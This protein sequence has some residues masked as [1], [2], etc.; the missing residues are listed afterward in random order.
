MQKG[1]LAHEKIDKDVL[2]RFS[3][4]KQIGRG[5]Y[6]IVWEV[7]EIDKN[8]Q[9]GRHVG[10]KK[11]LHAF[12]NPADAQRTYREVSYLLE[13]GGHDNLLM[14]HDVMV[15]SDDKHLYVITDLMESDLSKAM[16]CQCLKPVHMPLIGYQLLRALKYLHSADVMHRDLKPSNILLDSKCQVKLADFGWARSAL[17]PHPDWPL[18]DGLMTDYAATRWYRS[19]EML[20]SARHYGLPVDLWAVGCVV[21]EMHG[22]QPLIPGSSTIDMMNRLIEM[23]GRPIDLDIESME[24]KYANFSLSCLPPGAAHRPLDD[25]F[26]KC[27]NQEVM[28]D[29]LKLLLQW[30]PGKRLTAGEALEH[31]YVGAFHNP[32]DEPAFGRRL[33]LALTDSELFTAQRY[34]DQIYADVLGLPMAKRRVEEARLKQLEEEEEAEALVLWQ[35]Q[36]EDDEDYDV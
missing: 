13:L 7:H 16:R 3:V 36:D 2:K 5:N 9:Q 34:R 17:T 21:G 24:A 15:S 22:E 8:G 33:V 23:L 6:G 4:G 18:P 29:F 14:A 11:V 1:R 26:S 10:L 28:V 20:L 27:E 30:N 32:D 25:M 19:P 31:P 12:R 35:G